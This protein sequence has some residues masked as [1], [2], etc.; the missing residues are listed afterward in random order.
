MTEVSAE[1]LAFPDGNIAR[2]VQVPQDTNIYPLIEALALP[3][4]HAL[5]VVNGGTAELDQELR[6]QLGRMLQDGAARVAEEEYL[7]VVTG[8][9][10]AGIFDL[11]GQGFARWGRTAPCIGVAVAGRVT[12]PGQAADTE[13]APLEPHH[14][15]FVLVEGEAWGDE[16]NTMY[17][18]VEALARS[19]PSLA[20]FAG[21]G[22]ITI[23]EMREN[24]HQKRK[25][26]FLAGSGRT[27]DGVLAARK[28]KLVADD[29][30]VEIAKSEYIRPFD[31]QSDPAE[32]RT[33]I[34]DLLFDGQNR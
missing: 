2:I 25:M 24:I 31:I 17:A 27:T 1:P 21:G 7:T 14:S 23:Q 26:I 4:P 16:T 33:L 34:R 5:L 13:K 18:L 29:R 22:E 9:T 15:H 32:L 20:L 30:L 6:V 12:W 19:C 28:S 10:Q 8:G 11:L 3:R